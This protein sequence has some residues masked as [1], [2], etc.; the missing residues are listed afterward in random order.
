MGAS[1]AQATAVVPRGA[2]WPGELGQLPLGAGLASQHQ[3]RK[4]C[5]K[6][7]LAWWRKEGLLLP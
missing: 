6:G 5:A 2:V 3:G 1:A 4:G 7:L